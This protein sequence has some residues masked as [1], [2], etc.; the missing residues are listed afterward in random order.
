MNNTQNQTNVFETNGGT[1]HIAAWGK[2]M[3]TD[4]ASEIMA[5]GS[6][7]MKKAFLNMLFSW[8]KYNQGN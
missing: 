5:S 6:D 4:M 3:T 1:E 8:Q 2:E 7:L